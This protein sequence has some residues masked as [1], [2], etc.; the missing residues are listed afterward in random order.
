MDGNK[1]EEILV[2]TTLPVRDVALSPDGNWIAVASEYV[3]NTHTYNQADRHSE[4]SVSVVNTKDMTKVRTLRDQPRAVKHVSFDKKGEHLAVSC[5]DG[6]IYMYN[7]VGDQPEM[8]K[9]VDGMIKSV[10]TESE[11]CAK[12]L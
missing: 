10:E 5:T 2:R 12:V 9:K 1:F 6:N 4:L 8:I 11:S 7:L 3:Q